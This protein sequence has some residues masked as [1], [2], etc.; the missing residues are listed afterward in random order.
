ML[1]DA[2]YGGQLGGEGGWIRDL[3]EV[4]VEQHTAVVAQPVPAFDGRRT[5]GPEPVGH[6]RRGEGQHFDRRA[7]RPEQRYDL[8]SIGYDDE[9]L[10][11][12]GH[13][14][15]AGQGPPAAFGQVE[16]GVDLVGPVDRDVQSDRLVW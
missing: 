15:L 6:H 8:R 16:R 3:A 5:E 7:E 4:G 12:R 2:R 10:R 14:L 13:D 9:A 11:H 1:D